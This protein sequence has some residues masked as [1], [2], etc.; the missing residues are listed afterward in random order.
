[1]FPFFPVI[2]T[3]IIPFH[4]RPGCVSSNKRYLNIIFFVC[5]LSLLFYYFVL[6]LLFCMK[7]R[8]KWHAKKGYTKICLRCDTQSHKVPPTGHCQDRNNTLNRNIN[9]LSFPVLFL[10]ATRYT[11]RKCQY[12]LERPT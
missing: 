9:S 10:H 6:L 8:E 3:H 1:M 4:P 11:H 7:N 5:F 12:L 2:P